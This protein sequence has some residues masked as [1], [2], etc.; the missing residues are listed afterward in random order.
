MIFTPNIVNGTYHF[1]VFK[2]LQPD[3]KWH[4]PIISGKIE[5][6]GEP[7]PGEGPNGVTHYMQGN[8]P[9]E[10]FI[11]SWLED[12]S[13]RNHD[14]PFM[15]TAQATLNVGKLIKC[16]Q[17]QKPRLIYAKKKLSPQNLLSLERVLN[18]FQYVRG[19]I[20]QDVPKDDQNPD[21]QINKVV[22]CREN[23]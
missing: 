13:K 19:T 9:T 8:D 18:D 2:C 6:F 23:L 21:S 1:N 17:C 3:C 20:L 7:V 10:K 12:S 14:M 11:P 5:P 16:S 4:S 22:F 15:P